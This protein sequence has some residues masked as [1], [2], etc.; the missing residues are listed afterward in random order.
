M[1]T[2]NLAFYISCHHYPAS[3][4]FVTAANTLPMSIGGG[5]RLLTF[6]RQLSQPL[7]LLSHSS[8]AKLSL[9]LS[10]EWLSME[11]GNRMNDS[12]QCHQNNPCF[13]TL[14][15][16]LPPSPKRRDQTNH[17]L[18]KDSPSLLLLIS[19]AYLQLCGSE[20]FLS[21]QQITHW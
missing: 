2:S 21:V 9:T 18:L 11:L 1:W 6:R 10:P 16:H 19:N 8:V 13:I 5:E 15:F 14:F 17:H 7:S 12:C 3:Q 20:H 4:F